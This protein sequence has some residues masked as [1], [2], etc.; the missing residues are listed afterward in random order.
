MEPIN[1]AVGGFD[2]GTWLWSTQ[3]FGPRGERNSPDRLAP[4][5]E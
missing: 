2:L 4:L 5:V 1:T 3:A